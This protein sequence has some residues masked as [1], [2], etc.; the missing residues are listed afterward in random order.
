MLFSQSHLNTNG[1]L[2]EIFLFTN[3]PQPCSAL[4]CGCDFLKGELIWVLLWVCCSVGSDIR[5]T[6]TN[7]KGPHAESQLASIST[8]H[9]NLSSPCAK[10]AGPKG[11]ESIRAVPISPGNSGF[12]VCAVRLQLHGRPFS[13]PDCPICP[14]FGTKCSVL[15]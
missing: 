13:N 12:P 9:F 1:V 10:R 15:V 11:A 4:C 14:F 2:T 3:R 7:T 6:L 5:R 8:F